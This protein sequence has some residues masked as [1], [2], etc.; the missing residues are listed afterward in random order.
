[1]NVLEVKKI[2]DCFDGSLMQEILLDEP[3]SP[4]FIK[5][6]EDFG[7]LDYFTSFARPFFRVQVPGCY[8]LK[9]IE[10]NTSLRIILYKSNPIAFLQRFLSDIARYQPPTD[11]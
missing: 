6:W 3:I 1:M 7:L 2:E 4:D 5:F 10:G 8:Y 9:G 11:K